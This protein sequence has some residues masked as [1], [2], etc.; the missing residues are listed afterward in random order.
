LGERI[1]L[2]WIKSRKKE[3]KKER[4]KQKDRD[5]TKIKYFGQENEQ[6]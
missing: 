5:D 6:N 4:R 1:K 3:K 2:N